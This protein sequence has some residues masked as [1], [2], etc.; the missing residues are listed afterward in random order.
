MNKIYNFAFKWIAACIG[1]ALWAPSA[2]S[3]DFY[4]GNFDEMPTYK[5]T[6]TG[7]Y[8]DPDR[9]GW[10]DL[11]GQVTSSNTS[12]TIGV[13][14]GTQSLAWQPA[15]V[16]FYYGIGFKVQLSPKSLAERNAIV[17]AFLANTHIAM[18]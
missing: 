3:A 10:I 6:T 12:T 17:E 15:S 2:S 5:I 11:Q 7:A 18:N 16:G 1:V 13:T 14:T 9:T 8:G 4:F